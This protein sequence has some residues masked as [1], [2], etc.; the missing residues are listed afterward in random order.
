MIIVCLFC[1]LGG[2]AVAADPPIHVLIVDGQNNHDWKVTTPLMKR[3]LEDCGKFQVDV[4]TSPPPR[5]DLSRFQPNFSAY[6]TV[7]LNYNGEP[8]TSATQQSLV[9]YVKSGGGLVVVHAANNAFADW[10]EY[11][12]MI[13]L[14][15]WGGRDERSGPY[16]YFAEG[17]W[18]RDPQPGP[19][20]RH[21]PQ[22]PFQIVVRDPTHPITQGMPEKW[23]HAQDELYDLLRGPAQNL[24]VLAT[25]YA[26]PAKGGSGRHEPMIFTVK[27]GEGR[28]F[29]TPM[30]HADYSMKC[31][32]FV[33]T[34]CRGTEWAATG[35]VTQ[36]IASD[37]PT[38][39]QVRS[40]Y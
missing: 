32:G 17:K 14:G 13:G 37:F 30:G 19:G 21:G 34:I 22:H 36:E 25:A 4:A 16:V 2:V 12:E 3:I 20:G 35:N 6:G 18:V 5:H 31:A 39:D 7:L 38:A 11:N 28:V 40:R 15:G 24:K 23:M 10:P 27:F 8:W 33:A 9:N 1:L 29:H 26:D